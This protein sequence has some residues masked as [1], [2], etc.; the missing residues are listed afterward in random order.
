MVDRAATKIAMLSGDTLTGVS[1]AR[2]PYKGVSK[3]AAQ[4]AE[5]HGRVIVPIIRVGAEVWLAE[6]CC[7]PPATTEAVSFC[8]CTEANA[9][10]RAGH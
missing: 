1:E 8:S 4:I 7:H 6:A 3:N 5:N 2:R 10:H 9:A